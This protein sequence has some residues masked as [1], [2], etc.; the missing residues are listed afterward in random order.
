MHTLPRRKLYS[1]IHLPGESFVHTYTSQ[2][3]ALFMHT[4]PRR[5]LCSCIHLPGESF[6]HTYTS[7]EKALFTH[8]P[9]RRKL[10]SRI[11]LPGESFFHA[12]TSQEKGQSVVQSLFSHNERIDILGL[13]HLDD[14]LT[15]VLGFLTNT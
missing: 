15:G 1:P 4:P 14:C 8:T 9:P 11:H 3:K 7:Q 5:K 10:C 2:E 12:Y 13:H 6:V